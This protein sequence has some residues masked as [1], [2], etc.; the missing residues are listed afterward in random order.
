[1]GKNEKIL[2]IS[3]LTMS[4]VETFFPMLTTTQTYRKFA[5]TSEHHATL[6][7]KVHTPVGTY[8]WTCVLASFDFSKR[9][10]TISM[11]GYSNI[12]L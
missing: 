8:V 9:K 3:L 4:R 6:S 7:T 1:M 10:S 12:I 2:L 11:L 5:E